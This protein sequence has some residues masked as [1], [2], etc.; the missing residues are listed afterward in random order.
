[1]GRLFGIAAACALLFSLTACSVKEDR[2]VCPSLLYVSLDSNQVSEAL[3]SVIVYVY[4]AGTSVPVIRSREAVADLIERP[5]CY[6]VPRAVELNVVVLSDDTG[7]SYEAAELFCVSPND[8]PELFDGFS[9]LTIDSYEESA[10]TMVSLRKD[11]ARITILLQQDEVTD[12]ALTITADCNG[13][14]TITGAA[15][16]GQFRF[17]CREVSEQTYEVRLPRQDPQSEILLIVEGLKAKTGRRDIY[18]YFDIASLLY[19]KEYDW[20]E[21]NL[22]D[23]IIGIGRDM[24][25]TGVTV[26]DWEDQDLDTIF[27]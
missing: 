10:F 4:A 9:S 11:Y 14:E 1:M 6:E 12:C 3:D 27:Q 7:L 23:A 15:R 22:K 18:G 16:R 24:M 25:L 17:L 8:C 26:L 20:T 5:A 19:E 2:S 21:E 13:V